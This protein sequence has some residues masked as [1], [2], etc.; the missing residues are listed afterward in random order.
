M[1]LDASCILISIEDEH[2]KKKKKMKTMMKMRPLRKIFFFLF[3]EKNG[4]QSGDGL[5]MRR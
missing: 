1:Q 5:N 4:L 3:G 2:K